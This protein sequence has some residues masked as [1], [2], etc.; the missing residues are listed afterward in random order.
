TVHE[1]MCITITQPE[2]EG[3][4]DFFKDEEAHMKPMIDHVTTYVQRRLTEG[5]R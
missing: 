5:T 4:D 2:I 3:A 1:Q